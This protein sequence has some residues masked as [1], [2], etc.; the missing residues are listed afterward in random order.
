M[1][2]VADAE[3]QGTLDELMA[4][5]L[6][7]QLPAALEKTIPQVMLRTATRPASLLGAVLPR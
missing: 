3:T 5:L 7:R 4:R 1:A 2:A 6:L